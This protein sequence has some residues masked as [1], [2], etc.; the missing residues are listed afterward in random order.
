[1][2]GPYDEEQGRYLD[3]SDVQSD[4]ANGYLQESSIQPGVVYDGEGRSYDMDYNQLD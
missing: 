3:N 4:L 2:S 1:M